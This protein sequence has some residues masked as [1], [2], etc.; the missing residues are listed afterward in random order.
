MTYYLFKHN[1]YLNNFVA[2]IDKVNMAV[3]LLTHYGI[4][5]LPTHYDMILKFSFFFKKNIAK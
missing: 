2:I 5:H 1:I 4:P 3:T